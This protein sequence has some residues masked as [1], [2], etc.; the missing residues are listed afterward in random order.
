MG[1]PIGERFST[2]QSAPL[3]CMSFDA[4][5]A[6]LQAVPLQVG[7]AEVP[8]I[9]QGF[10]ETV[11]VDAPIGERFSTLQSAPLQRMSFDAPRTSLQ[12]VPLQ[13]VSA[14]APILNR[15]T[16][17]SQQATT[18]QSASMGAPII[19]QGFLETVAVEAPIGERFSTLQ[20]APL[21][22]VSVEAPIMERA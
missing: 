16:V 13:S 11:A 7:S 15:G 14:Q 9:E 6:S 18:L 20:S 22:R 12:A 3:Q 5:R 8:I 4:P 19:E 21:Q 1:A 2:L 10:V 17:G